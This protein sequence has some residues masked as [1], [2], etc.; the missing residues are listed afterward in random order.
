MNWR[1]KSQSYTLLKPHIARR[2]E[3]FGDLFRV[4]FCTVFK[5]CFDCAIWF[6]NSIADG[7]A[8]ETPKD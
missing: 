8:I 4:H 1:L 7:R 5:G 6:A 3:R 2:L